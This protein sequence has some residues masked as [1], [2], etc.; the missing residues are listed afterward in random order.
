MWLV[1]KLPSLVVAAITLAAV[2]LTGCEAPTS[3]PPV[4]LRIGV[5]TAQDYL[6]YYAMEEQGLDKKYGL[7]FTE[8]PVAGGA[9]A[10]DAIANGT[11]DA[12]LAGIV[13]VLAAAERGLFPE[14]IVAVA[15][16][17]FADLEHRGAGVLVAAAVHSW[18]DLEG[19]K[20]GTNARN[21]ILTAAA[22]ARLK[23]EGVSGYSFLEIPLPNL[24]LALAGGNV[25]AAVMNEPYI[26]Q[27]MLRGDGKLLD[28]VIGG[29]PFEKMEVSTIVFS[30]DFRRHNPNGVKAFLRAHLAAVRWVNDHPDTAR[31]VLAKRLNLSEEVVRKINLLRWPADAR[32]DRAQLEQT[33]Q[34]LLGANV[35]QR[36]T[37][38]RRIHDETLLAEV[39]KE[40]R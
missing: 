27:S 15:A 22:V 13:P 5:Y 35:L 21:S 29:P 16:N 2:A 11:M 8:I 9:A 28:W 33:Q 26:T 37:D 7:K 40:A 30:A 24:G 3:A 12:A 18:K 1:A 38:A 6:P 14:K 20:I 34:V 39:L 31:L 4:T 25:A 32:T 36:P 19:K 10:I 23:Q 17:N